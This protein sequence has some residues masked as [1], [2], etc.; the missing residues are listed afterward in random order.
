VLDTVGDNKTLPLIHPFP[1]TL[2]SPQIYIIIKYFTYLKP[3]VMKIY[4]VE[5]VHVW[6]DHPYHPE[7]VS[8][9]KTYEGAEKVVDK[10]NKSYQ[11]AKANGWYDEMGHPLCQY[12]SEAKIGT[13]EVES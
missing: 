8:Y 9:H 10:I 7:P 12:Q 13:V 4:V 3:T 5:A 11:F 6:T 1:P 2:C